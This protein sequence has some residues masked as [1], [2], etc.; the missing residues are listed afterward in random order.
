MRAASVGE[1]VGPTKTSDAAMPDDV[2]LRTRSL[3][4]QCSS[5]KGRSLWP[6]LRPQLCAAQSG[7]D[8]SVDGRVR[9]P[10][11]GASFVSLL[12]DVPGIRCP[13]DLA[14]KV[15]SDDAGCRGVAE[16]AMVSFVRIGL[17]VR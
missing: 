4:S 11:R 16:S 6:S 14:A 8:M 10:R 9:S 17:E 7:L 5:S 13:W 15:V 12:P 1:G 3:I 2:T